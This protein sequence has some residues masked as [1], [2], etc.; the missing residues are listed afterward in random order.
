MNTQQV[1]TYVALFLAGGIGGFT[2]GRVERLAGRGRTIRQRLLT[3]ARILA[4]LLL[5]GLVL[6]FLLSERAR[7][8][9]DR[10]RSACYAGYFT[11]VSSALAER[12]AAT[13]QDAASQREFLTSIAET[14][15][16]S[17]AAARERLEALDR[18]EAARRAAPLPTPPECAR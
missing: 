13:G 16:T 2:L 7:V 3:V 12:S 11:A 1:A 17:R 9:T 10:A 6:V 15:Q 5:L 8:D 4:G 18:L 14:G